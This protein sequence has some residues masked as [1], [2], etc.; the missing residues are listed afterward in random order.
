MWILIEC[1]FFTWKIGYISVMNPFYFYPELLRN[2]YTKDFRRRWKF[3]MEFLRHFLYFN[4]C[5]FSLF[6][7]ISLSYEM[8]YYKKRKSNPLRKRKRKIS[9]EKEK[10]RRKT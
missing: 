1:V 3:G 7:F 4:I 10:I 5:P 9:R 8:G 6:D 2:Y